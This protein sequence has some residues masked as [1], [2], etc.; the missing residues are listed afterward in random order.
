MLKTLIAVLA[1]S[2]CS[3]SPQ[4]SKQVGNFKVEQLF[5]EN[6]CTLYRFQDGSSGRRVYFAKCE[7]NVSTHCIQNQSLSTLIPPTP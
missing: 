1:L 6:G 3:G 4:T 7:T 2:A 5:T